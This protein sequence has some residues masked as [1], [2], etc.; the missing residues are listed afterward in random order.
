[1]HI[2]NVKNK[3]LVIVGP[4]GSGKTKVAIGVAQKLGGEVISADSRAIY[5][6][7]DIGTAKPTREEMSGVEHFGID[8]VN[9]DERFTVVD[10][11][12]YCLEKIREIRSREKLP[13]IAGGTGLYVDAVIY[14][15]TFDDNVKKTCSDRTEMSSDFVVVGIKWDMK[16]LEARLEARANN[17]FAQNVVGETE[18]LVGKYGLDLPAMTSNI[19]PVVVRM[20]RGE[21]SQD[22]AKR[23][24]ALEDRH[25][26]KRQMTWFKRNKNII[27]LR[28][29]EIEDYIYN[30]YR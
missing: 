25:L 23:L 2:G 6:D 14:D 22:E 16:E 5:R 29:D 8:L 13:I 10:F 11:K 9:P 20:L 3:T 7:M 26:A 24:S 12:E 4:T 1:M 19:Y 21:I 18:V 27:W 15:Y 28:L 30:L 17:L